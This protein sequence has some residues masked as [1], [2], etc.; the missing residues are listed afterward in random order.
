MIFRLALWGLPILYYHH[1]GAVLDVVEG[2]IVLG[3]DHVNWIF[4]YNASQTH[5]IT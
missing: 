2:H 1:R 4:S 5:E 3:G